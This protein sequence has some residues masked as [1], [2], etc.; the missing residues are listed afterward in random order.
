MI[1]SLA[2]IEEPSF[3]FTSSTYSNTQL[4]Q[5]Q[6]T[7]T[8]SPPLYNNTSLHNN[9]TSLCVHLL[10]SE[11]SNR[12]GPLNTHDL[13]WAYSKTNGS[14]KIAVAL[15]EPGNIFPTIRDVGAPLRTPISG[16]PWNQLLQLYLREPRNIFPTIRNGGTLLRTSTSGYSSNHLLRLYFRSR[17]GLTRLSTRYYRSRWPPIIRRLTSIHYKKTML[18]SFSLLPSTTIHNLG[19]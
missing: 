1:G 17:E 15:R 11:D 19:R 14:N 18:C 5:E 8:T 2:C 10:L 13:I 3:Q 16:Y 7:L 12:L 4:L 9:S 6:S